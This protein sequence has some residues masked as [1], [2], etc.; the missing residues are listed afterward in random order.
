MSSKPEND[1]ALI[2]G[3]NKM[4]EISE[5]SD[6]QY[7]IIDVRENEPFNEGHI[8]NAINLPYRSKP[9]ALGFSA[10]EF[11]STFGSDKPSVDKTLVIYC[12]TGAS[13]SQSDKI[14]LGFGYKKRLLYSASFLDW[15]AN[16]GEVVTAKS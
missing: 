7:V 9:N 2:I 6:P 13:A 10:E 5:T 11:K 16:N 15:C 12:R 4:K 14:A 3:F 8:P 1:A